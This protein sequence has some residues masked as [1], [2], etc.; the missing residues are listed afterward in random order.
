MVRLP[1]LPPLPLTPLPLPPL[2][3][4]PPPLL[5]PPPP[6]L[7]RE[8]VLTSTPWRIAVQGLAEREAITVI[9]DDS[10]SV[11]SQHRHNLVRAEGHGRPRVHLPARQQ[12]QAQRRSCRARLRRAFRIPTLPRPHLRSGWL[13]S[14]ASDSASSSLRLQV[15]VERYIYFPSSRAS[16]GLKGPSLM[17]TGRWGWGEAAVVC[18]DDD[19]G[20]GMSS[21]WLW[22]C[23]VARRPCCTPTCCPSQRCFHPPAGTKTQSAA[24]SAWLWTSWGGCTAR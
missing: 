11:W 15:A 3:P 21:V 24:C 14:A 22:M 23:R 12:L 17:E 6:L 7:R 10:H 18:R 16:L 4:L 13:L 20:R 1:P 8:L 9:V 5:L 19:S 2:P